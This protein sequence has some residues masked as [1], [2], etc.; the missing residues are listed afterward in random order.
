[1]IAVGWV[2]LASVR[3]R[4]VEDDLAPGVGIDGQTELLGVDLG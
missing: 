2:D 4:L 3:R 1:M